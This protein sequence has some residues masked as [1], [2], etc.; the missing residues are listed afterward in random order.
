MTVDDKKYYKP[1]KVDNPL[2]DSFTVGRE[3]NGDISISIFQITVFESQG[4]SS[5]GYERIRRIM[6]CVEEPNTEV[7]VRY[8]LVCP[9]GELRKWSMPAG[10]SGNSSS[11]SHSGDAYCVRV[12]VPGTRRPFTPNFAT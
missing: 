1:S 6:E 2:F 7:K 5:E 4:G 10:W 12:R 8:F 9:E 3:P 11:N